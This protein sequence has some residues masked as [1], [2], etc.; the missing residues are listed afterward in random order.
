L[1]TELGED[2]E[3]SSGI[4]GKKRSADAMTDEELARMLAEEENQTAGIILCQLCTKTF[5]VDSIYILDECSHKYVTLLL[6]PAG[7][8]IF[9]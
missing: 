5:V 6:M 2:E 7:P 4:I 1:Q 3:K 8:L 9:S